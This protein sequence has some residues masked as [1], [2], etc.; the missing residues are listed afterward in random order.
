MESQSATFKAFPKLRLENRSCL[1]CEY[2][3]ERAPAYCLTNTTSPNTTNTSSEAFD[4]MI[5][6]SILNNSTKKTFQV[7]H[8]V[9]CF[10]SEYFKNLLN[11][12]FRE[13]GCKAL[14][15]TVC[16]ANE[17]Q[18]FYDWINTGEFGR[19]GVD[20]SDII[21]MYRFADYFAIP[22]L[23]NRCVEMYLQ[24]S[25]HMKNAKELVSYTKELY[26]AT[27]LNSTLRS[28]HAYIL[29]YSWNLDNLEDVADVMCKDALMDLLA[30]FRDKGKVPGRLPAD[31]NEDDDCILLLLDACCENFHIHPN[32]HSSTNADQDVSR[33]SGPTKTC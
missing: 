9:L 5:T 17:F 27:P 10:Y 29:C 12:E 16:T 3:G 26:D 13:A 18:M 14:E 22:M 6:V 20:P 8:G 28:V 25:L 7:Y 24:Y 31:N 2:Y 15:V 33:I 19:E 11:G 30:M 32:S 21:G 23:H 4:E 1:D